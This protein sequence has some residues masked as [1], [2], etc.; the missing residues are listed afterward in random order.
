MLASEGV[1][2]KKE[3]SVPDKPLAHL[4][5]FCSMTLVNILRYRGTMWCVDLPIVDLHADSTEAMQEVVAKLHK[6][7]G[8]RGVCLVGD[9]KAYV[10]IDEL[11]QEYGT[12]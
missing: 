6:A 9:Q 2:Q 3:S 11:K 5:I 10:R 12:D 8:D 4:K 7:Y 1:G